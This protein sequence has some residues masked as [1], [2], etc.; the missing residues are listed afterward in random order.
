MDNESQTLFNLIDTAYNKLD[1]THEQ[2]KQNLFNC[3]VAMNQ[4]VEFDEVVTKTY[5]VLRKLSAEDRIKIPEL[6]ALTEYV[7]PIYNQL[8]AKARRKGALGGGII[9]V[10]GI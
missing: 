3:A 9:I 2:L 8:D 10:G 5:L 4:D 1:Q 7:A 6:K